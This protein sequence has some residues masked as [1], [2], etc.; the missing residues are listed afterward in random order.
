VLGLLKLA[1][2]PD[3]LFQALQL[4]LKEAITLTA[5]PDGM[6]EKLVVVPAAT[7]P[8]AVG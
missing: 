7:V 1:T 6:L 2:R 3:Q 8:L 5:V 4:L